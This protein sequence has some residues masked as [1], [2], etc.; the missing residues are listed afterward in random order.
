MAVPASG[1][2]PSPLLSEMAQHRDVAVLNWTESYSATV[3]KV[4]ALMRWGA[5]DCGAF[6]VLRANDD[7]YLRLAPVLA[8]R[9]AVYYT[10]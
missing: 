4:L 9:K 1:V 5:S 10:N 8:A 7:V 2:L 6:Y 3:H